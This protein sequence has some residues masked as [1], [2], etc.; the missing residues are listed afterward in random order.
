[1][2][3]PAPVRGFP[4]AGDEARCSVANAVG[5]LTNPTFAS[6]PL[7][8]L[9]EQPILGLFWVGEMRLAAA[10][11]LLAA[12][13]RAAP[14]Y[15]HGRRLE[16]QRAVHEQAVHEQAQSTCIAADNYLNAQY[17]VKLQV[18]TPKQELHVVPDTGS[19]EVVLSSKECTG[20]GGHRKFDREAS[21]TFTPRCQGNGGDEL[22][23]GTPS[24]RPCTT[25]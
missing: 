13:V 14:V 21:T 7:R 19:F 12:A 18:G 10:V 2:Y 22:R 15:P 16:E 25:R 6:P 17:T 4:R 20:C 3:R 5:K 1:M 24:R 9:P 23:A 8:P 11:A